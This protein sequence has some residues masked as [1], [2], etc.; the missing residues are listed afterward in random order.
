MGTTGVAGTFSRAVIEAMAERLYPDVR[1]IILPLSNPTAHAE[2]VPAD[3]LAWTEGRA[4]VTT[5]SPFPAFELDGHRHEIGQA[6]NAFIFPG[7]GMGAIVAEARTITDAMFLLAARV[8]AGAVTDERLT[9][10]AL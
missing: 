2:A 7:V 1:P 3:V 5:G 9:T 6:N 4:L 10:G 8:L